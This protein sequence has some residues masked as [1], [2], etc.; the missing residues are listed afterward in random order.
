M[1]KFISK[2]L[3]HLKHLYPLADYRDI[4]MVVKTILTVLLAVFLFAIPVKGQK[5]ELEIPD[6]KEGKEGLEAMLIFILQ[7]NPEERAALTM[8]LKPDESDYEKVFKGKLANK[9]YKYHRRL[10]RLSDI[11][12]QPLLPHQ[13]DIKLWEATTNEL[14]DYIAEARHFPG[15]YHEIAHHLHEGLTFYRFKFV[16]PGRKLGSAYDVM[17]YVN[18]SWKIF[19]RPWAVSVGRT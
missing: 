19:H 2:A 8:M 16:E 1:H 15:G 14:K 12:I 13:T 9:V 7:A 5:A 10:Y 18:G 11:I 17:V 6:F 4:C 3:I